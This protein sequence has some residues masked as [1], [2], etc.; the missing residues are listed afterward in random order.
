VPRSIS[1]GTNDD[2]YVAARAGVIRRRRAA[3]AVVQI[4]FM[5]GDI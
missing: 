2:Q 5:G 1:G 4:V 3:I